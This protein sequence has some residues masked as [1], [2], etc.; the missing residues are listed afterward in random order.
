MFYVTQLIMG[1]FHSQTEK[2]LISFWKT[3]SSL[4]VILLRY[5]QCYLLNVSL[6]LA[7]NILRSTSN[8]TKN[9]CMSLRYSK[10]KMQFNYKTFSPLISHPQRL[11]WARERSGPTTTCVIIVMVLTTI[12]G[13]NWTTSAIITTTPSLLVV[14]SHRTVANMTPC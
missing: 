11:F 7:V 14:C 3:L 9:T 1:K 12:V 4:S 5:F 13:S 2:E 6:W 10:K 8:P